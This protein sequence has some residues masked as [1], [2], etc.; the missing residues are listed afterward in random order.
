MQDS[1]QV[2][3][4]REDGAVKTAR[5]VYIVYLCSIVFG[6]LS[7]V[8]VIFAYVNR[9]NDDSW[10]DT[11][12]RFQIRT[13]WMALLYAVVS[14][15]A[16]VIAVGW[17]MLVGALIWWIVRCAKGLKALSRSDPYPNVKTWLW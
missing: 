17:L 9:N 15:V 13:F 10:T 5:I 8:G 11:H 16:T 6:P 12:F 1:E 3:A 7:L 4:P 14:L 2:P